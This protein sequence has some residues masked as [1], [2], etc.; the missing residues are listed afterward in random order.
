MTYIIP[1]IIKKGI[2]TNTSLAQ[3][4]KERTKGS[5][6]V[7]I[8]HPTF[9]FKE[10]VLAGKSGQEVENQV[11]SYKTAVDTVFAWDKHIPACLWAFPARQHDKIGF[12][13]TQQFQLIQR[14]KIS[15]WYGQ[16]LEAKANS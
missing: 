12:K 13:L 4:V 8:T 14:K 6:E 10:W 5:R 16:F 9:I 3:S 7:T 1:L 15:I 2:I 11:C